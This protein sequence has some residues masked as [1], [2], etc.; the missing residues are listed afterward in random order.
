MAANEA[1]T[2]VFKNARPVMA[3]TASSLPALKP[4]QPNQSSPVPMAISGM[5]F[6]GDCLSRR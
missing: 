2:S 1:A 3:L 4:Y 5:L 6:G